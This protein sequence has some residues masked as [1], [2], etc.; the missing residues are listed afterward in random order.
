MAALPAA[1]PEQDALERRL[2]AGLSRYR[3]LICALL[4]LATT[5]NYIDRQVIG[6]LKPA[7]KENLHWDEIDYSNIVMAF[8]LAY[9]AGL[10][11]MGRLVDRVGVKF[12]LGLAVTL[13]SVAAMAHG[14]A[15]TV[16]GF[17]AARFGLGLAEAGNFPAAIKA[18]GEWF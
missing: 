12:G 3:W 15:R 7:L 13:W 6:V 1:L 10:V 4:F 17:A 8:Q 18:V 16:L 5:I 2:S 9:A 11:L 14:L